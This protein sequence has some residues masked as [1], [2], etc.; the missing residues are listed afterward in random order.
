[1]GDYLDLSYEMQFPTGY[2][3]FMSKNARCTV[4]FHSIFTIR[5]GLN[6]LDRLLVIGCCV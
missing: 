6:L 4:H 1:M 2:Y 5:K 3:D